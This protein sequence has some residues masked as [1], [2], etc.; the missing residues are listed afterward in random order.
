[1][2][3]TVHIN[4]EEYLVYN[5]T[6]TSMVGYTTIVVSTIDQSVYSVYLWNQ[7]P[8][9]TQV[10]QSYQHYVIYEEVNEWAPNSPLWVVPQECAANAAEHK[11]IVLDE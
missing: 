3:G 11:I 1:M 2:I 4:N 10:V 5:S 8:G 9:T 7:M 6:I